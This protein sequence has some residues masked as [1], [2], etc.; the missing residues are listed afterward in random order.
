MSHDKR[1]IQAYID[2]KD[3]YCEIASIAFDVPYEECLEFRPDG[4]TNAEGKKKRTIAKA[5]VLGV[6]YGKGIAA[7]AEDLHTSK[8]K[9]SQI[10]NTIMQEFPG[11]KNFIEECKDMAYS[12]GYVDTIWGR[13]RRLP[14]MLLPRYEFTY[15]GGKDSNFDP[16]SEDED[17]EAIDP[18]LIEYYT[19]ELDNTWGFQK[20]N[21]IKQDALKDGLKIKDNTG[22]IAESERQSVNCVDYETEVLTQEG[23]KTVYDLKESDIVL[24]L[25]SSK[26]L[27][28]GN[29]LAIH[30]YEGDFDAVEFTHP[31]CNAITT[32]DHRW[33]IEYKDYLRFVTTEK[34]YKHRWPDYPILKAADNDFEDNPNYSDELLILIGFIL[35]DGSICKQATGYRCTIYQSENNKKGTVNLIK[36]CLEKLGIPYKDNQGVYKTFS[37]YKEP[38]GNLIGNL[39]PDRVLTSEFLISLSQR[40]LK[41]LLNTM[42]LGDGSGDLSKLN[43]Q[44]NKEKRFVCRDI[45][46]FDMF[47]MLCTLAGY[48]S[49]FRYDDARGKKHYSNKIS[50]KEGYI[51]SKNICYGAA[52]LDRKRIHIYPHH[53]K[54]VKLDKVWCITTKN[55]TWVARRK[56]KVFITGNS[57]IQ[58]S[59]G[60][61][62]KRAMNLIYNDPDMKKWGFRMLIPIHDEILG[63]APLKFAKEAGLKLQEL[64]I[65]AADGLSIPFKCDVVWMDRWNGKEYNEDNLDELINELKESN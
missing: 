21:S 12:R 18:E 51:L 22:L 40:Q 4:T 50:N 45:H 13:K 9:A 64:M 63:E 60:D 17:D 54:L 35:T 29:I 14:N 24:T 42:L 5:I 28:W 20:K 57:R 15:V 11:L 59:A 55:E 52:V 43:E 39:F 62:C 46:R 25:N 32:L 53:K 44:R 47:Q 37:I 8:Q 33:P 65:K 61:M 34:I 3:L 1:M 58:G 10:Y 49:S 56:G 48:A 38:Y 7:I 16:L 31:Q 23:W 36:N 2:G 26:K 30:K 6:C 27:E 19:R 41:I